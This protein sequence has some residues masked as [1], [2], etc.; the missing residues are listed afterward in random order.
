M[1]KQLT[2]TVLPLLLLWVGCGSVAPTPEELN[3]TSTALHV[4][5]N[6]I[7]AGAVVYG[8]VDNDLGDSLG[9]TPLTCKYVQR[10]VGGE[11]ELFGTSVDQTIGNNLDFQSMDIDMAD[12]FFFQ[13]W[14]IKDGFKKQR[15][16][17]SLRKNEN[18]NSR[19]FSTSDAFEPGVI[20]FTVELSPLGSDDSNQ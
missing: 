9:V 18:F 2:L 7:P 16:V 5:V 6:S 1:L 20:S 11:P 3:D 15:V 19:N 13:C 4:E 17:K 8:V 10:N 12:P 14:L